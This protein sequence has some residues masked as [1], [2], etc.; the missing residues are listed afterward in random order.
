MIYFAPRSIAITQR[1]RTL[2]YFRLYALRHA[3]CMRNTSLSLPISRNLLRISRT[4]T[5]QY[6]EFRHEPAFVSRGHQHFIG[7]YFRIDGDAVSRRPA[8]AAVYAI[9]FWLC[10]IL[11]RPLR[12]ALMICASLT[13]LRAYDEYSPSAGGTLAADAG[14][15]LAGTAAASFK[16]RTA[17]ERH[18]P[19]IH[20]SRR[21]FVPQH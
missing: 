9:S 6:H 12:H 19:F 8:P 4:A 18:D 3:A 20:A 13:R 11:K 16:R 14:L 21:Y 7:D 5:I 15:I 2:P 17:L 10:A 1:M